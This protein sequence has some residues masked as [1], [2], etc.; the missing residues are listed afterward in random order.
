MVEKEGWQ[1]IKKI[2]YIIEALL[3]VI[4]VCSSGL[5]LFLMANIV[6]SQVWGED[7]LTIPAEMVFF[8]GGILLAAGLAK[9]LGIVQYQLL[10]IRGQEIEAEMM[11][12][13]EARELVEHLRVK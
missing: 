8:L 13:D 10:H 5:G 12:D 3:L 4:V 7:Y 1:V 11:M 2:L 6:V 9:L